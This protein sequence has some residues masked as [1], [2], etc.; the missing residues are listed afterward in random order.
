MHM[1]SVAQVYCPTATGWCICLD[2]ENAVWH[3]DIPNKRCVPVREAG[4]LMQSINLDR[5]CFACMH[6]GSSRLMATEAWFRS[7]NRR[8]ADGSGADRQGSGARYGLATESFH[9]KTLSRNAWYSAHSNRADSAG[10]MTALHAKSC[11]PR[12]VGAST[13][14]SQMRCYG[15][16]TS[17]FWPVSALRLFAPT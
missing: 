10:G 8:T 11:P 17:M 16:L 4:E 13:E 14:C 5:T 12:Q 3:A 9:Q 7:R 2:G 15:T 6:G 1:R